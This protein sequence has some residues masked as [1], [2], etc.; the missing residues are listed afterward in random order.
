MGRRLG[1]PP[2]LVTVSIGVAEARFGPEQED[3]LI[4]AD[5]AL[6]RAKQQGRNRVA[7]G[8]GLA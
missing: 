1:Y 4:S 8:E 3:V 6:Y 2:G 5:R 7:T